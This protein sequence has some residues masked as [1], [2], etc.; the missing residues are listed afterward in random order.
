MP[1]HFVLTRGPSFSCSIE[2]GT[3]SARPRDTVCFCFGGQNLLP[4]LDSSDRSLRCPSENWAGCAVTRL[5]L[6]MVLLVLGLESRIVPRCSRWK[7][8]FR[9]EKLFSNGYLYKPK[10]RQRTIWHAECN[11]FEDLSG[12]S[13][14]KRSYAFRLVKSG[15]CDPYRRHSICMFS[16]VTYE[17]SQ[18]Q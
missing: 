15:H 1:L 8:S 3:P 13:Y 7:R 6:P 12:L 17:C 16:R 10:S 11:A 9:S 2:H 14:G 5:L 18:P 4:Q